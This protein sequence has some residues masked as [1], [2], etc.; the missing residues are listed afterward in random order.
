MTEPET[1]ALRQ[2]GTVRSSL[3][4]RDDAPRQGFL[5][6]PDAWLD[7]DP[8]FAEGI[9]GL[10]A[11]CEIIVLTWLH[12]ADRTR[13]KT[14]THRK[15]ENPIGV[16]ATRSPHRPNPIGLHRVTVLEIEGSRLRVGP[17]EAVNGTPI[18]DLKI[19]LSEWA[20]R[21]RSPV[22]ARDNA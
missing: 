5:G 17:L 1:F 12:L 8:R 13:L 4:R 10:T 21:Q 22:P 6:A 3:V 18:I 19:A 20:P 15:L 11:N 9:E 14:R 7:I 16:F 2:I